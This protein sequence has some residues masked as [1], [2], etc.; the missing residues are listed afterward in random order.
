MSSM[1]AEFLPA[2]NVPDRVMMAGDWHGNGSWAQKAIWHGKKAG[3]TVVVHVG[4]FGYWVDSLDT[5]KYLR[6]VQRALDETG[7]VLYWVDGNHEAHDR[8][9]EWLDAVDNQ[10]W[11]DKRYPRI[12]HL[13][14]GFRWEWHDKTWMSLGGA[15]SVDRLTR[16]E[17]KSW[18]DGEHI[19]DA[20]AEYASRPGEVHVMVCHDCPDGVDI[21]GIHADEKLDA[22]LSFWPFSEIVLA[23]AHRKKLG[24]VVDVVRPNVLYHGHYHVKYRGVWRNV[25]PVIGLDMDATTLDRNTMILDL[26]RKAVLDELTRDSTDEVR[27]LWGNDQS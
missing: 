19:T 18:W 15:H 11:A 23:N 26:K 1:E 16:T 24:R 13:P 22:A 27:K 6:H 2:N 9:K 20:E 3:A 8:I 14:R 12:V 5:T 4:D 17:G 10:P 21:P 7:M 25:M